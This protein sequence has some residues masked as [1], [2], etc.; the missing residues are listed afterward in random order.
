MAAPNTGSM[1]EEED[2][3]SVTLATC[4]AAS[5]S[6]LVAKAFR[7]ATTQVIACNIASAEAAYG[8]SSV[9]KA[10]K[11]EMAMDAAEAA[12]NNAPCCSASL[13]SASV[14]AKLRMRPASAISERIM[15]RSAKKSA[16]ATMKAPAAV[17]ATTRL[18]KGTPLGKNASNNAGAMSGM[19]DSGG[20]ASKSWKEAFS[21]EARAA[22][23]LGG[24]PSMSSF[25]LSSRNDVTVILFERSAQCH[26]FCKGSADHAAVTTDTVTKV[27]C[28]PACSAA[29]FGP[30]HREPKVQ[31]CSATKP[32]MARHAATPDM[33]MSRAR[34]KAAP[35]W[36]QPQLQARRPK[37]ST[38]PHSGAR[39]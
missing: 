6:N 37:P 21:D 19:E 7:D 10:M 13:A 28:Q 33:P 20:P 11:P 31:C 8:L 4:S 27:S 12:G 32:I 38:S 29:K 26:T 35:P 14:S 30:S 24:S 9:P 3:C 17:D 5:L 39:R 15:A 34:W 23:L 36:C 2:C 22:N 25:S 16:P 18:P 1:A